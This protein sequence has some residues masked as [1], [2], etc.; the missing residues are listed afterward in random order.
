MSYNIAELPQDER[1]KINVDLAAAGV[2]YKERYSI[3]VNP[4]E[5]EFA[6]PEHLRDYFRVRLAF[7]REISREKMP[8]V[9]PYQSEPKK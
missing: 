1:D 7:F 4:A 9:P 2:A 3:A 8:Q 6:Q 5:V